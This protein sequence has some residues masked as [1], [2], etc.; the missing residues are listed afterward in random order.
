MW[1]EIGF[2]SCTP[3]GSCVNEKQKKILKIPD[4]NIL[5]KN[6][7]KTRGDMVDSYLST[8]FHVYSIHGF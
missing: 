8:K 5:K 4:F 1:K 6:N 2:A 3:I 7:K